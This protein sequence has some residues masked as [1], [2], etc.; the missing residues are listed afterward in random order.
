MDREQSPANDALKAAQKVIEHDNWL[1]HEVR[2]MAGYIVE[3]RNRDALRALGTREGG[4][5]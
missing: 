4:E 5:S 2:A 3:L 1:D